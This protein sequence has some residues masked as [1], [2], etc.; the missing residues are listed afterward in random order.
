MLVPIA[1]LKHLYGIPAGTARRWLSEGK[2]ARHGTKKPYRVDTDDVEAL[3]QR[4]IEAYKI[5]LQKDTP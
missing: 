4:H 2:L 1:A 5:R 3:A